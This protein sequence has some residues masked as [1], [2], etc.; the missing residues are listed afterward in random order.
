LLWFIVA[1]GYRPEITPQVDAQRQ[2]CRGFLIRPV[3]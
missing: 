1:F 3:L 2:S